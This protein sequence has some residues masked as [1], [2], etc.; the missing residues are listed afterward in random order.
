MSDAWD[1]GARVSNNSWGRGGPS[2]TVLSREFDA[3]VR[4]VDLDPNDGDQ[5]MIIVA[6]TGNTGPL[7]NTLTT[8]SVSK[9]VISGSAS[10][11]V[12]ASNGGSSRGISESPQPRRIRVVRL[13][14]DRNAIF[15]GIRWCGASTLGALKP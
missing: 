13:R 9:N 11:T 3:M 4:D 2:Y 14:G 6:S 8:P 7:L 1:Q 10:S 5:P 15:V 12:A